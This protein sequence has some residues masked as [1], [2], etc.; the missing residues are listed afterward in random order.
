MN[1]IQAPKMVHRFFHRGLYLS[2]VSNVAN[3]P[4]VIRTK[5]GRDRFNSSGAGSDEY[6]FCP[7]TR[8]GFTALPAEAAG[9]AGEKNDLVFEKWCVHGKKRQ[10]IVFTISSF[11]ASS[12]N[13]VKRD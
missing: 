3:D 12:E 6:F 7:F 11:M 2:I 9:P 10:K 8:V 1:R 5:L 4:Q 13:Q